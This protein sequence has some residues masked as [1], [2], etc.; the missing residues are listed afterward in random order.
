[1]PPKTRSS[2]SKNSSTS[3]LS[4]TPSDTTVDEVFP[5]GSDPIEVSDVLV[6]VMD[7]IKAANQAIDAITSRLTEDFCYEA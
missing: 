2:T 1:M 5:V 6:T 7:S 4:S 3:G